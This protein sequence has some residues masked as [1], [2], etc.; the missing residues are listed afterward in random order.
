MT[1]TETDPAEA[2]RLGFTDARF[3]AARDPQ[4]DEQWFGRRAGEAPPAKV[5]NARLRTGAP[6]KGALAPIR[7]TF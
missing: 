5:P 1:E 3:I 6:I 7:R 4:P 2:L